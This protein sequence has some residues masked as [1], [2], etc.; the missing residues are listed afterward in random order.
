MLFQLAPGGFS[1]LTNLEQLDFKLEK[2]IRIQKH[3]GKVRKKYIFCEEKFQFVDSR[4]GVPVN[5]QDNF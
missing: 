5:E 2:I 3:A 4:L 1:Y